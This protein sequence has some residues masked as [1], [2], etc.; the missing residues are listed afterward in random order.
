MSQ[1]HSAALAGFAQEAS[2]YTRGRPD[3]PAPLSG[4]LREQL[5][6][7]AGATV[8]DLGAGTGKFTR[9]L[10]ATGARVLAVEPVDAMRAQFVRLLPQVAVLAGTAQAI[11]I[12]GGAAQALVCA[13]AFHWFASDAALAE[14]QRVLAPAGRLGLIWN[15]RDESVDWVA[16]ISAI[17]APYEGDTPRFHSGKW[18]RAFEGGLFSQPVQTSFAYRHIGNAR[19]VIVDRFMSVS[20]IAALPAQHKAGVAAE[21]RGLIATHPQLKDRAVIEFPYH[22]H[23]YCCVSR[24]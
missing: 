16:A 1:V 2:A 12:I 3:Y 8:V 20:F 19:E 11:P 22:T 15:V 9:L 24:R 5:A 10:C 14:M 4:W 21:L 13:Q 17:I 7:Q 18:L 23:A 6:L